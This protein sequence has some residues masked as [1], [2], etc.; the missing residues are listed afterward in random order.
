MKEPP[1]D[2][3]IEIWMV[4]LPG[5][6]RK[7]FSGD[8]VGAFELAKKLGKDVAVWD[9]MSDEYKGNYGNPQQEA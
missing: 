9:M 4:E 1:L 2:E 5:K 8:K 6:F 7:C 3:G